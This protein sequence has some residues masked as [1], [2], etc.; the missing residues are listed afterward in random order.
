M[1]ENIAG[2]SSSKETDELYLSE[3][4]NSDLSDE[5]D[6]LF[7]DK[8]KRPLS[9]KDTTK[10][11]PHLKGLM[12]E[13]NLRYA[14]G[15][16]ETA[17]KMCFE[18]IRQA[19]DVYEPYLTLSQMYEST[20][21]KKY[22]AYLMLASHLAPHDIAITCRLADLC[23][24]DGDL[25]E[26]IKCYVR[27]LKYNPQ[28]MLIHTKRLELL[29]QRGITKHVLIAKQ[30]MA[31][32]IPRKHSQTIINL[33]MEVAKEHY[34]NKSYLRAIEA[35][36]IPLKRIPSCVTQDII[37]VMLELLL[38]NERFS[39]C[40]DIFTQFCG[41]TF[42]VTL[43]EDNNILINSFEIPDKLPL[44]LKT[45]FISCLVKLR[46]EHLFPP[47]VNNMLIEEDVE[48]FGDLYLDVAESLMHVGYYQEALKLLIALVKSKSFSLA[49]VW[50]K[51]AEC[52]AA[53]N[54]IEQAIDAYFTVRNLAPGHVEVLYPLAMLLL[55]QNNRDEALKV[56]SQD[57]QTNKLDVAVLLEQMKLLKQLNDWE[58][59]WTSME[60]LLSRHCCS[61]KY[62]E[63]L[64]IVLTKERYQEKIVKLK[65]MRNFR[66]DST[67]V[68]TNFDII[69]EPSIEEEYTLYLENL[70][71]ALDRK[72]CDY[73]KKFVFMGLISKRFQKYFSDIHI[74]AFYSCL[75]TL[76]V[77]HGYTLIR[78]V[79]VKYPN[80]NLCWNW[81][82]FI[83]STPDDVR[84]PRFLERASNNLTSENGKIMLANYNLCVGNYIAAIN[85]FLKSFKQTKSITSAF[86]LAVTMLQ[87]YC[88]RRVE[89]DKKRLMTETITHL[90]INY[91]KMR[92]K[93]AEQEIYYNLG[94]MYHQLGVMYLA[95]YYYNKVFK[96][97]NDYLEKYPEIMCLKREAA[98]NLHVIYKAAGNFI[99]A[100]NILYQHIVI[101]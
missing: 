93:L 99:A 5:E 29:E 76:D 65:K 2:P 97:H 45:K 9:R 33:S 63:E 44:D 12:G 92:T 23:I 98:F 28:N 66:S 32:N 1:S 36:R 47:M 30:T 37:N 91:S 89:K 46:A 39:D 13:A 6:A 3:E 69:R 70:Q 48:T 16:L 26:G 61:L 90:F 58:G 38:I 94:R 34:K 56:M 72:E 95:E 40:L 80:N 31:N 86:L 55:K 25:S 83:T 82:G 84:F 52:L 35:L 64:K 85:Y 10:L 27:S 19:P 54:L 8:S 24:Q 42:D 7:P 53:C 87:H 73:L 100:R 96:V 51:Y 22:K 62:P 79:L 15:D 101:V 41:F 14:R 11:P 17:K 59:Y 57:L 49:G 20:N 75:L 88:N 67:N 60:L 4:R 50:L 78:D 71:L 81:F 68:E 18:V 21:V 74:L 77:F 43:T